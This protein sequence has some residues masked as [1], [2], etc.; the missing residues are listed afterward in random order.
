MYFHKND[1]N[2]GE[3]AP[4]F[5]CIFVNVFATNLLVFSFIV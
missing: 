3:K 2:A 1:E 4:A 5:F